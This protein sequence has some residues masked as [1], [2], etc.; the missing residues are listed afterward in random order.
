V[1]AGAHDRLADTAALFTLAI[2]VW[3]FVLAI[4]GRGLDGNFL[5]AV[6]VGE[7]LLVVEAGLGA[8]RLLIAGAEPGRWVHVL[9]GLVAVL[10]WPFLLSYT[11]GGA[12]PRDA[13]LFGAASLFLWGIVIRAATTAAPQ[14]FLGR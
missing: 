10:I 9:Y 6:L 14:S 5:G 12:Q 8:A 4:R 3:A 13:A 2:A 1:I 11:R 7:G